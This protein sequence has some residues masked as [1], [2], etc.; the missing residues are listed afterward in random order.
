MPTYSRATNPNKS[1][2]GHTLFMLLKTSSP[3]GVYK[4][5]L[6]GRLQQLEGHF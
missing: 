3:L 6:E 1:I 5:L 4:V 2:V